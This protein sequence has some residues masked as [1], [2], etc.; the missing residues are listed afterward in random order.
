M[1][2]E[3]DKRAHDDPLG[4]ARSAA[5]PDPT[6][7]AGTAAQVVL[8]SGG[9]Y[10]GLLASGR[11]AASAQVH[12]GLGQDAVDESVRA[13]G[14]GCQ[15]ADALTGVVPLLEIRRQLVAL[16]TGHAGALLQ[17]LGHEYLP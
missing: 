16:G 12:A 9:G 14:G 7:A 5:A 4:G 3:P 10:S 6:G 17:G 15:S 2:G 13:S 8:R 1:A 11:P